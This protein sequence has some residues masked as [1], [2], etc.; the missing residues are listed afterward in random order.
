VRQ[1]RAA[2]LSLQAEDLADRELE[3]E[4]RRRA[5]TEFVLLRISER[6]RASERRVPAQRLLRRRL[7]RCA[8]RA[9]HRE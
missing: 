9:R 3:R 8:Q 4:R 7:R 1:P 2:D 6:V 5:E